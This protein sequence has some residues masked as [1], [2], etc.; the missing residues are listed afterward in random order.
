[1]LRLLATAWLAC[2]AQAQTTQPA[3]AFAQAIAKRAESPIKDGQTITVLDGATG[4]PVSGASVVA[5]PYAARG[6]E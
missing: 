1:M 2:A 4:K 3:D 5:V 6:P